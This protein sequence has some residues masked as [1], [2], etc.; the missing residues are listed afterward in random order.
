MFTWNPGRPKKYLRW[1][2]EVTMK[3]SSR[4]KKVP[5]IRVTGYVLYKFKITLRIPPGEE[6][7]EVFG[8]IFEGVLFS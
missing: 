6:R 8:K 3:E 1:L 4:L 2:I 5:R 7:S